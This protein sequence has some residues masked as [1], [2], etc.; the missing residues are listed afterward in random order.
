[1]QESRLDYL[2][3][4][5]TA[6]NLFVRVCMVLEELASH[7]ILVL[8]GK[9]LAEVVP[10]SKLGRR[11]EL[12]FQD[13][14]RRSYVGCLT[15]DRDPSQWRSERA[16]VSRFYFALEERHVEGVLDKS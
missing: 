10:E 11:S 2:D 15:P 3:C 8:E 12:R 13:L 6:P 4:L 9:Q 7:E 1:L 5:Q 14:Q 16:K